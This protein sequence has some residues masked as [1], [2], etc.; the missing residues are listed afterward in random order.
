MATDVSIKLGV[1]GESQLKSALSGVNAQMKALKAEMNEAVS[2]FTKIT[3]AE[4][5]TATQITGRTLTI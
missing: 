2:G 3:S 1:E 5:K 4:E